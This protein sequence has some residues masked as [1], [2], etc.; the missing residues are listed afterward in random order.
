VLLAGG[1]WLFEEAE[2]RPV[3]LELGR[4]IDLPG[5]AYLWFRVKE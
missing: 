2:T 5:V 3:E 4:V 1:L